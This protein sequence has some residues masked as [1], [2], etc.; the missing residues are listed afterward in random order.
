MPLRYVSRKAEEKVDEVATKLGY[1]PLP[2]PG[3]VEELVPED[4]IPEPR[5]FN[6]VDKTFSKILD[7]PEVR[8]LLEKKLQVMMS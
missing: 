1:E 6:Q 7:D 8:E 3:P 5:L 4:L 2:P